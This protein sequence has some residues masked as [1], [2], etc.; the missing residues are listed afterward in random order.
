M[1]AL[2]W[3][4]HD[5]G[6]TES[7]DR[8]SANLGCTPHRWS[9][10]RR[11]LESTVTTTGHSGQAG[12]GEHTLFPSLSRHVSGGIRFLSRFVGPAAVVSRRR[13]GYEGDMLRYTVVDQRHYMT[14]CIAFCDHG[15]GLY[16]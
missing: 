12:E 16:L 2:G 10:D 9:P 14:I 3:D 7:D 11:H 4:R 5:Q 13:H 6:S 15:T 8:G 1:Q